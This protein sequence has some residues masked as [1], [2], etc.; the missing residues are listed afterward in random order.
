MS[1]EQGRHQQ[2]TVLDSSPFHLFGFSAMNECETKGAKAVTGANEKE[3]E[4]ISNQHQKRERPQSSAAAGMAVTEIATE[5]PGTTSTGFAGSIAALINGERLS[6]QVLDPILGRIAAS[7]ADVYTTDSNEVVKFDPASEWFCRTHGSISHRRQKKLRRCRLV[8]IS[9]HHRAADHWSLFIAERQDTDS[10]WC[11][12]HLDSLV[13]FTIATVAHKQPQARAHQVVLRYLQWLSSLDDD[14]LQSTI[15]AKVLSQRPHDRLNVDM[16]QNCATQKDAVNCGIYLL[17]NAS[18]VVAN[19]LNPVEMNP[20]RLRQSY[21]ALASPPISHTTM[22]EGRPAS[23]PNT[24]AL[25]AELRRYLA[26]SE[27]F[28]QGQAPRLTEAWSDYMSTSSKSLQPDDPTSSTIC[29]LR[30]RSLVDGQIHSSCRD[31]L[32]QLQRWMDVKYLWVTFCWAVD[33]VWCW[34]SAENKITNA[35]ERQETREHTVMRLQRIWHTRR[36]GNLAFERC[37]YNVDLWVVLGGMSNMDG[38]QIEA[39]LAPGIQRLN[40]GKAT[41][42]FDEWPV[43]NAVAFYGRLEYPSARYSF[44]IQRK[45][46]TPLYHFTKNR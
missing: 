3:G 42:G 30:L 20:T 16:I 15:E 35:F 40:R 25:E 10:Q 41:K 6:F 21:M 43:H 38:A 26:E 46:Y 12:S 36:P 8:M 1:P 24:G 9:Y 14:F 31:R 5:G 2:E 4:H 18:A 45:R 27:R 34:R 28:L 19:E 17:V 11:V 44:Q 7:R 29:P 37:K 39:F 32:V 22:A 23:R 13:T 33:L